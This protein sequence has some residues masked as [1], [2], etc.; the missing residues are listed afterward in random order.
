MS[1]HFEDRRPASMTAPEPI[2][3][4]AGVPRIG[5]LSSMEAHARRIMPHG[6]GAPSRKA[7]HVRGGARRCPWR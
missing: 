5:E 2:R 1:T 6:P 4:V 7:H 3:A